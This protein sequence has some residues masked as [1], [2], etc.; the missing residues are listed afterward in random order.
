MS[1][2]T[3]LE[4]LNDCIEGFF[5]FRTKCYYIQDFITFLTKL[6]TQESYNIQAFGSASS[7]SFHQKINHLSFKSKKASQTSDGY[8]EIIPNFWTLVEYCRL[9]KILTTVTWSIA[10]GY[11]FIVTV[12]LLICS[13]QAEE[14]WGQYLIMI[15]KHKF[16]Y[17]QCVDLENI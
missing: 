4:Q 2:I 16:S 17:W 7:D 13:E 9:L 5:L 8:W 6:V 3:A 12:Y 15:I 11:S 10:N 14:H 1:T